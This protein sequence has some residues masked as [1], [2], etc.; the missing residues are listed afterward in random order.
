[1]Y[2]HGTGQCQGKL[3][4]ECSSQATH[5]TNRG[6]DGSQRQRHGD[7]RTSHF[8]RAQQG[9]HHGRTPG[10]NMTVYVFNHYNRVVHDQTNSQHHGQQGQQV[11][12]EAKGQHQ[13]RGPQHGQGNGGQGNQHA[14]ERTQAHVNHQHHDNHGFGQGLQYL[15]N[16]GLNKAGGFK[17]QGHFYAGWQGRLNSGQAVTNAFHNAQGIAAGSGEQAQVNG[18]QTIH[19]GAGFSCRCPQFY[20]AYVAQSYQRGAILTHDQVLK[21][22]HAGQVRVELNMAQDML[23]FDHAGSGLIVVGAYS[24]GNIGSRQAIACHAVRIQPQSH[25]Q[26]LAAKGLDFRHA[27]NGGEHGLHHAGQIV[28]Q[29]RDGDRRREIGRASCRERGYVE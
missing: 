13:G 7:Y 25:G 27:I 28:V 16:R 5:Q 10:S 12:A 8:T 21:F 4:E 15:I 24:L 1:G 3:L 23:A 19:Q 20:L 14:A 11:D 18:G 29:F 17:S 22:G 2:Q 6:I 26:F 9:G